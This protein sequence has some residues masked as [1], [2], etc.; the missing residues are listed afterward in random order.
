MIPTEHSVNWWT[1]QFGVLSLIVCK[2]HLR[3]FF[4]FTNCHRPLTTYY[5]LYRHI[6][7]MR[8]MCL[9]VQVN[10][11]L[12]FIVKAP[13]AI[14]YSGFND[15]INKYQILP[16]NTSGLPVHI[17]IYARGDSKLKKRRVPI[18]IISDGNYGRPISC[19]NVKYI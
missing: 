14:H 12:L 7:I 15:V 16:Q 11:W 17:I 8:P 13:R 3:R 10:C 18:E 1:I 2:Y 9:H 5:N 19:R 6:Y 4:N